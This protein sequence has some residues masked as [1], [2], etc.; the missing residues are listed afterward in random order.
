MNFLTILLK[1]Q[2][3]LACDLIHQINQITID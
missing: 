2:R 3:G 1:F